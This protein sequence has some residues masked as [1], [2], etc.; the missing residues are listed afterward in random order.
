MLHCNYWGYSF[1][2]LVDCL[3]NAKR[4]MFYFL[5]ATVCLYTVF[6]KKTPFCFFF[7]IHSNDEQYA[8]NFYQL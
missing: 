5:S 7:I 3:I 6:H 8:W 1:P 4:D 2:E